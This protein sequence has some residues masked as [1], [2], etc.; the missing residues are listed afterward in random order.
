VLSSF[1]PISYQRQ[2]FYLFYVV[3]P[4]HLSLGIPRA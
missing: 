4:S 2:M 1:L 3:P